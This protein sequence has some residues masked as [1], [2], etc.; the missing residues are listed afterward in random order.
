MLRR[1][2]QSCAGGIRMPVARLSLLVCACVVLVGGRTGGQVG[3]GQITG[4]VSD[5]SGAAV[6]GATVVATHVDTSATRQTV[7][8]GAGVY[9]VV[10]LAPG[11]Y[12]VD[13]ELS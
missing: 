10:G 11:A 9:A 4:I 12:R 5:V 8:T 1:D 2:I 13:V 3:V 6:P 7:T